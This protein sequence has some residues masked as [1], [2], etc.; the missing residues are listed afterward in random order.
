[1]KIIFRI[2]QLHYISIF[3][4]SFLFEINAQNSEQF[5]LIPSKK[6]GVDFNNQIKDDKNN[7][8]LKYANFYGGAGVGIGDFNND[9]LKDIYFAGNLVDDKLYLNKG[10]FEFD[11]ITKSSGIIND[12]SWS[13]GVTIADV[14]NDGLL[15]I[16]VSKELYDHQPELRKNKL[17]INQGNAIFKEMANEFGIDNSERTRHATFFDFDKDGFLDL[18]ILN[19][20]PNPGSYSEYMGSELLLPKYTSRLYKN[21]KGKFFIDVTEKS[22]LLQAGFPNAVSAS[23]INNDGWTD[24]YVSNDFYVP[25]ALYINNQNGTFTN[26]A[27]SA[28]NHMSYYSMGVDV[29]DINN[30]GFLDVFVLDMVAEDNFRLKSNMSGMNPDAFW[31]IVNNGGHYQYMFNNFHL[32]NGNNTFSEIAQLANLAATDWSWANLIADFDNDGEKD[33]YITNGLLRDIRNTDASKAVGSFVTETANKWVKENPNGGAI[34]IWDIL[35]LQ[36]A[37]SLLPSQQLTNFMFKNN[38]NFNFEKVAEEWGLNQ[39]SFS[40]GA[41]YADLDNDG[42]LDLVVNNINDNAFIYKNNSKNNYLR[43]ELKSKNFKT[44]LGTRIT[45]KTGNKQQVIEITNVRGVYSTSESIAHFGIGNNAKVDEILINWPNNTSTQLKDVN[46]NQLLTIFMEDDFFIKEES[47]I[48][49][50][51]F[52]ELVHNNKINYQH[53]ENSFDDFKYQVLLPHKMSQFGPA[54][55]VEDVNNDGL[56]DVFIGGASGSSGELFIQNEL[57]EFELQKNGSF[58]IDKMNEDLDALFFDLDSDGDKDLYVVSGG[59]EYEKEDINYKD[60]V[61][62]NNGNGVFSKGINLIQANNISGSVVKAADYDKDGDIDIFIGARIDPHNYPTPVDSQLLENREGILYNVTNEKAEELNNLGMVTDAIWTDYDN[63]NDLDLV[64]VGEWMPI[65]IFKNEENHFIKEDIVNFNNSEGWWFSIEQGDFDNDGDMDFVAGN[66]GLN[67][68]YKATTETP[69]DMYYEDFDDNGSNDIVLGYYNYGKH[70]PLRGFSCSSQQVP[71]LKKEFKKYDVFASLEIDK[72][73]GKKKLDEALYLKVQTFASSFIENLGSGEFKISQLPIQAQF[74]NI[75]DIIVQD[76]NY[77]G[78]LDLI[79]AG[80]LF[81]SEIETTRN[82]AGTGLVL[83]GDGNNNF[84]P[85][86]NDKSGFFVNKD[87]KKLKLLLDKNQQL[88]LVG[89]N[90]EKLQ[91]FKFENNISTSKQ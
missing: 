46:A 10:D 78:N 56:K 86:S 1:M 47:K 82:D 3:L 36:K 55:A 8:I 32:N 67:Y 45:I 29:S 38:G 43:I 71:K 66:L 24:L 25:D 76:L 14:N 23:D 22:G 5:S 28:L 62:I 11:D 26:I 6:S 44:T 50:T 7:N 68:K 53:K 17:Y 83:L 88:I 54:L 51:L 73:Y 34:T 64:I 90:N 59:N 63:D 9:G 48:N 58:E 57:G 42:D 87:V 81:V 27:N 80:N 49:K 84:E 91:I 41:A 35:D 61:Y 4:V 2:S 39:K 70:Y 85:I 33:I 18:F 16:Y 12:G 77:D 13:T 75:N 20:P 37:L 40:N 69:F 79:I 72:V 65:T 60:R 30:D 74:S 19:Q 31:K 15:D 52:T 21:V 89:N